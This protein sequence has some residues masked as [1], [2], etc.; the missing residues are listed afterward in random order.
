MKIAFTIPRATAGNSGAMVIMA[1][2][3][4]VDGPGP[5]MARLGNGPSIPVGNGGSN[6]GPKAPVSSLK[7]GTPPVIP[8][9]A[10]RRLGMGPSPRIKVR[11]SS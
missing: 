8:I 7:I 6:M 5:S 4:V 11:S 10:C 3:I 9:P 1:G 2:T